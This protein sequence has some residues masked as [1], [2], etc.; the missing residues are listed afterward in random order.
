[1]KNILKFKNDN[2]KKSKEDVEMKTPKH[3]RKKI[4]FGVGA[5]LGLLVGGAAWLA[6]KG[7]T[8]NDKDDIYDDEYDV[9]DEDETVV[10]L[11]ESE[12]V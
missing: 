6:N 10:D 1:M 7:K 8:E 12:E 5:G 3:L 9:E 11:T 2:V 4:L